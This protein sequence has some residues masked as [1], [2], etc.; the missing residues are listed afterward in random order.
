LKLS[1]PG[2]WLVE[3]QGTTKRRSWRKFH[4]GVDAGTGQ[5]A[6]VEL[7]TPELDDGSQVG[8]LLNQVIVSVASFTGDGAYDQSC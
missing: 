8:P 2:E 4:L 6:A 7:T 3:K 1:G 5:I